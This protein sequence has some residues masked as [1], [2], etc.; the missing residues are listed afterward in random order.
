[1]FR[2]KIPQGIFGFVLYNNNVGCTLIFRHFGISP[3]LD[4]LTPDVSHTNEKQNEK[5]YFQFN[6]F[7]SI[8]DVR[9]NEMII[10]INNERYHNCSNICIA[11]IV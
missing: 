8:F 9:L 3:F 4:Y 7:C 5:F 6:I 2:L 1:M 11:L 10:K